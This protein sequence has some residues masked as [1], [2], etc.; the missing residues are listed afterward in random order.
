LQSLA[1]VTDHQKV[2]LQGYGLRLWNVAVDFMSRPSAEEAQQINSL[3]SERICLC[4]EVEHCSSSLGIDD[5]FHQRSGGTWQISCLDEILLA[6][7]KS[8]FR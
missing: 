8:L 5:V 3:S 4:N 2:Q 6:H 1:P 7:S